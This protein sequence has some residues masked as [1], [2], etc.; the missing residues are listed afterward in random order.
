M[1]A[2]SLFS[3]DADGVEAEEGSQQSARIALVVS[4]ETVQIL[5]VQ[6]KVIVEEEAATDNG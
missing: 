1:K 2:R 4:D 6:R 3:I 5:F